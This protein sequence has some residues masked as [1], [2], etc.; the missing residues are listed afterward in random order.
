MNNIDKK[1][2]RLKKKGV[3]LQ[4]KYNVDKMMDI[5]LRTKNKRISNK[6]AKRLQ[7]ILDVE[8][9]GWI[10]LLDCLNENDEC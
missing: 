9:L 4:S 5:C 3:I 1:F 2:K 7:S 10:S 8:P 6:I